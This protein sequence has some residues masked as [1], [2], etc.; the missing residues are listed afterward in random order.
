MPNVKTGRTMR[1]KWYISLA[2]QN[3]R[4]WYIFLAEQDWVLTERNCWPPLK[5]APRTPMWQ[6]VASAGDA[7]VPGSSHAVVDGSSQVAHWSSLDRE[8]YTLHTWHILQEVLS[9]LLLLSHNFIRKMWYSYIYH[10]GYFDDV[11]SSCYHYLIYVS[12]NLAWTLD[13]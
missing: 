12:I 1:H 2:E 8:P 4:I 10:N 6:L 5:N 3:W 11:P 9:L 13:K 7:G